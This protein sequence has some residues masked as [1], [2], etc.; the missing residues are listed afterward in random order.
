MG[1]HW[2]LFKHFYVKGNAY[3]DSTASNCSK[4]ASEGGVA[5]PHLGN[6][7]YLPAKLRG[8]GRKRGL[9]RNRQRYA[10][11]E[12]FCAALPLKGSLIIN[13]PRPQANASTI[14]SILLGIFPKNTPHINVSKY[15][16]RLVLNHDWISLK[17][18]PLI[19]FLIC[20][21]I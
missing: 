17:K 5:L 4:V 3:N 2:I 6:L 20:T 7:R 13:G 18:K 15:S 19:A 9:V 21:Y 10:N 1:C 14:I 8:T 12:C 11:G 16:L